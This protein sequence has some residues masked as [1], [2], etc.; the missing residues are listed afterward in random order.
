MKKIFFFLAFLV[1]SFV[2]A[3]TTPT[4]QKVLK[5]GATATV[6][7]NIIVNNT[8]FV[9]L[10]TSGSFSV[11]A[12]GASAIVVGGS[13]VGVTATKADIQ[14]SDAVQYTVIQAGVTDCYMEAVG[15]VT[16][17]NAKINV[18]TL[19]IVIDADGVINVAA[20]GNMNLS[21]SADL[22]VSVATG[23]INMQSL[24]TTLATGVK[25]EGV[26]SY[27]L[28]ASEKIRVDGDS[29]NIY[30]P[31][32][33]ISVKQT[34]NASV[35]GTALFFQPMQGDF[36][37]VIIYLAAANGT[38]SYTFP[39]AFVQTPAI[40]TTDQLLSGIITTLTTTGVTITGAPSTGFLII[41]GY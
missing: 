40:L 3:Q 9:N 17:S 27:T 25:T 34:V 30:A 1:S 18:D 32:K 7:A 35:S 23:N 20:N 39:K 26:D 36:K 15:N 22:D 14:S 11:N 28:T 5:A 29:L 33:L 2:F 21:S 6:T 10:N 4:L 38:A 41:E 8:G 13:N 24:T 12:G 16:G 19:D 37:K 31:V